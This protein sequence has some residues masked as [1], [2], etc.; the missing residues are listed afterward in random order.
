LIYT[1]SQNDG[2]WLYWGSSTRQ[3]AR[4]VFQDGIRKYE[5]PMAFVL[6]ASRRFVALWS[7]SSEEFMGKLRLW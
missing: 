2:R 1:Q 3:G 4:G 6:F 7:K 5:D